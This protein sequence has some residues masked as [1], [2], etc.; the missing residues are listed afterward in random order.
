V[1]NYNSE[2]KHKEIM[3]DERA[4]SGLNFMCEVESLMS[5]IVGDNFEIEEEYLLDLLMRRSEISTLLAESA[6][7]V[8]KIPEIRKRLESDPISSKFHRTRERQLRETPR[9]ELSILINDIIRE[10]C[11]V[12]DENGANRKFYKETSRTKNGI[13]VYICR[14]IDDS[15]LK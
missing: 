12:W 9:D 5:E 10:G 8:Q 1:E 2:R 6:E 3:K 7:Y 4:E 13:K 11:N 14:V 15:S